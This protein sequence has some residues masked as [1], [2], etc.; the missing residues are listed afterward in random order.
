MPWKIVLLSAIVLCFQTN[1]NV[2]VSDLRGW[3]KLLIL[4]CGDKVDHGHGIYI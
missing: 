1:M 3:H 2:D 4:A